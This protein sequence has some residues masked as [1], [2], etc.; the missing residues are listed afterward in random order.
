MPCPYT[1]RYDIV[2]NLN[3]LRYEFIWRLSS[4]SLDLS[5]LNYSRAMMALESLRSLIGKAQ[6]IY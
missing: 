4:I 2:P 5:L 3:V 1:S 6:K